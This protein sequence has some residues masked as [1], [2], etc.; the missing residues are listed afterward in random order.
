MNKFVFCWLVAGRLLAVESLSAQTQI[1]PGQGIGP[2]LIGQSYEEVVALLGFEG[3]LKTFSD[4]VS[5]VL[6]SESPDNYLECRI[7]FDYY[8]RY[9]HL[10]TLPVSYV[11][12]KEDKINQIMV[13]SLP[14]YYRDLSRDIKTAQG[15]AFWGTAEDIRRSYGVESVIRDFPAFMYSAMFY[16]SRGISFHMHSG[17]YRTA[18]IFQ[19]PGADLM[20]SFS[21]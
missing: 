3:K 14:A 13:S 17:E 19:P 20:Q 6:F 11:F 4:Y 5:E 8:V 12:Y 21:R 9:E 16:F 15:S 2:L 7:G 10:L 18:H 1:V